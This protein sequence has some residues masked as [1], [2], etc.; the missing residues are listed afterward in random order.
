MI[1]VERDRMDSRRKQIKGMTKGK[2]GKKKK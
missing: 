2:K 1:L